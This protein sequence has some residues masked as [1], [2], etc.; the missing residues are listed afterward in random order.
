MTIRALHTPAAMSAVPMAMGWM[1][2]VGGELKKGR[3]KRFQSGLGKLLLV[4]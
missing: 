2:P 3:E 4:T 1:S